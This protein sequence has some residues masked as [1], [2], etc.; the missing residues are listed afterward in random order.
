MASG[1]LA[2][3]QARVVLSETEQHWRESQQGTGRGV[4]C[5]AGEGKYE[6]KKETELDYSALLGCWKSLMCSLQDSELLLSPWGGHLLNQIDQASWRVLTEGSGSYLLALPYWRSLRGLRMPETQ[7]NLEIAPAVEGSAVGNR[8]FAGTAETGAEDTQP[9]GRASR[10]L[11]AEVAAAGRETE[12]VA[13]SRRAGSGGAAVSWTAGRGMESGTADVEV[14]MAAGSMESERTGAVVAET[15]V[16]ADTKVGHEGSGTVV[17][18]SR[19]A[20]AAEGEDFA[21]CNM[22]SGP[23]D[24]TRWGLVVHKEESAVYKRGRPWHSAP[25]PAWSSGT[26]AGS[27]T[28]MAALGT[29]VLAAVLTEV[30]VAASMG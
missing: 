16:A 23:V 4:G 30:P 14:G 18:G 7:M 12:P 11:A 2:L 9:A 15:V 20:A 8:Q 25:G 13:V 3:Q 28:H 5:Q 21:G 19:V 1:C 22:E 6:E 10:V 27:G 29:H 24:H 26:A 17:A